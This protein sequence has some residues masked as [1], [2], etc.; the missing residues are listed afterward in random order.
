MA[1]A[2]LPAGD[3]LSALV[4]VSRLQGETVY[5]PS[6]PTLD[7]VCEGEFGY[8]RGLLSVWDHDGPLVIVEHDMACTDELVENLLDCPQPACTWAYA[9]HWASTHDDEHYAQR[10][11]SGFWVA[12]N[13]PW[14]QFTGI[15]LCKIAAEVRAPLV[16]FG[17][18]SE[19]HWQHVDIAANSAVVGDWH[20]HWPEVEHAHY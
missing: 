1:P 13:E 2:V 10:R 16:S 17:G 6:L 9:L 15:G 3:R 18:D 5:Q 12:E 4:V 8:W 7:L 11:A 19:T 14:C 20:I